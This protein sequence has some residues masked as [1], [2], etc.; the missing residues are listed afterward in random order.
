MRIQNKNFLLTFTVEHTSDNNNVM[1]IDVYGSKFEP[2]PVQ[3]T[4]E[5]NMETI[6]VSTYLPNK[7]MLVLSGKNNQDNQ[8]IKLL[9]MSLA[10]IKI[11]NSIMLN[12][13]DYRPIQTDK[14]PTSLRDYL[15]NEAWDP[16][17]WDQNGCV[18]FDIFDPTP[19]SYLLY[20]GNKINF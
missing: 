19:F 8:S 16:M 5:N 4:I 13:I 17:P 10:G 3:R 9:S 14:I 12:L 20:I 18:L 1:T 2:L 15:N 7:V 11:N 6:K